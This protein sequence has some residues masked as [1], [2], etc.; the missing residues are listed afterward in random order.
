MSWFNTL[1][2]RATY[3]L[4]SL[5][6]STIPSTTATANQ[7][8]AAETLHSLNVDQDGCYGP[9]LTGGRS[10]ARLGDLS[11]GLGIPGQDPFY[12]QFWTGS[13][14][15]SDSLFEIDALLRDGLVRKII[16]APWS[17]ALRAGFDIRGMSPKLQDLVQY[18]LRRLNVRQELWKLNFL[19]D[20]WG[21]AICAVGAND[22][23]MA[24]YAF[25]QQARE[26][27]E[28]P[29]DVEA[30]ERNREILWLRSFARNSPWGYGSGFT[31][32]CAGSE[33]SRAFGEPLRYMVHDFWAPA[34]PGYTDLSAVSS[35][36]VTLHT[37]RLLHST[38]Y[39][40]QSRLVEI[41]PYLKAYHGALAAA[42]QL[43][44]TSSVSFIKIAHWLHKTRNNRAESHARLSLAALSMSVLNAIFLDK[45]EESHEFQNRNLAG[46]SEIVGITQEA[47]A[48]AATTPM[49]ILFGTEPKGFASAEE[50]TERYYTGVE[51]RRTSR[52]TPQL[53]HLIELILIAYVP[54]AERPAPQS[55]TVEW[56]PLRMPTELEKAKIR[57]ATFEAL[58]VENEAI[59]A[60][61][62][63]PGALSAK[64]IR[65]VQGA[66]RFS[67]DPVLDPLEPTTTNPAGPATPASAMSPTLATL[68]ATLPPQLSE[69]EKQAAE[70]AKTLEEL[71]KMGHQLK[72]ASELSDMFNLPLGRIKSILS[73]NPAP[74]IRKLHRF[75]ARGASSYSLEDFRAILAQIYNENSFSTQFSGSAKSDVDNTHIVQK[76]QSRSSVFEDPYENFHAARQK[77]PNLFT[78]I[79]VLKTLSNGVQLRGGTLQGGNNTSIQSVWLPASWSPDKAKSW[80]NEYGYQSGE[81][82]PA[83]RHSG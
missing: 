14:L 23:P 24:P 5:L 28:R 73:N 81:F 61:V 48:G 51:E 50:V 67:V 52:L 32:E 29:L 30:L 2:S 82:V 16:G 54:K 47:L 74:A 45:D 11:T 42:G 6:S 79:W 21:D 31:R 33:K 36:S 8:D 35:G 1:R 26:H 20:G 70:D 25:S 68:Q 9:S 10:A 53:E 63:I 75:G 71:T 44:R 38:T 55:W 40:A 15:T 58:K 72:T 4:P 76:A 13:S 39:D 66:D 22:F 65:S 3:F 57:L 59:A 80:L 56:R 60:G 19:G 37:S 64:E 49:A 83:D 12:S 34:R 7:H 17:D 62:G 18:H 46:V 78:D 27:L 69:E 41:D 43:L 77:D